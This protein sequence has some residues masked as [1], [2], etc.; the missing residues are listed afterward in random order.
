MTFLT[1]IILFLIVLDTAFLVIKFR[2]RKKIA[3]ID[4]FGGI[5]KYDDAKTIVTFGEK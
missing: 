1:H 2:L 4:G 3:G 5:C